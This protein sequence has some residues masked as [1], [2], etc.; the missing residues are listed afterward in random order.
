MRERY[1][2]SI[3]AYQK[4]I[5][6]TP[7][8]DFYYLFLGRSFMELARQFPDRTANPAFD[9]TKEDAMSTHP[10][11]PGDAGTRGPDPSQR[12]GAA[13]RRAT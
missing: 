5:N 3:G 6:L 2:G 13:A 9:A 11:A 4:A 12:A 8:Q 10:R 7:G 1:D